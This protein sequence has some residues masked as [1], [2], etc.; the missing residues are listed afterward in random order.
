[1]WILIIAVAFILLVVIVGVSS[2]QKVKKREAE[3][4]KQG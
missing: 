1:M 4:N 2:D 3:L